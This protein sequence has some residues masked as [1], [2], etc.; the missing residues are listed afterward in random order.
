MDKAKNKPSIFERTKEKAVA[1]KP[2]IIAA[3]S[4]ILLSA[5]AVLLYKHFT[6]S[7]SVK[8]VLGTSTPCS[9]S[10][11]PAPE[12]SNIVVPIAEDISE[13]TR[14]VFMVNAFPRKLP[15]GQ[16]ASPQQIAL[17]EAAK[18][19]LSPGYTYVTSHPRSRVA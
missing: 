14:T 1:H 2:E 12:T 15:T 19:E 13:K 4:L 3:C 5:T 6:P 17:A 7:V 16:H 18:I 8:S 11:I 10:H 9:P